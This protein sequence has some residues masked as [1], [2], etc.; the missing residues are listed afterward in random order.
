MIR[1]YN[2]LIR[3]KEEF[4]PIH[5]GKVGM[6]SCGPT[7]Y[8]FAHIGNMRSFLFADVLRRTLE[9][10]GFEVKQ[11]MNITDVGHL[12]GDT[13]DGQD[14]M[15]VAMKREGKSAYEIAEFY[16]TAFKKDLEALNIKPANIYPKA[17]DHI[18][19]QIEMV[20]AL[21]KNGFTYQ[22]SD[23]IYFDTSKLADYGRLS[24]QRGEEK[25]AGARVEM[26]EKRN[27][28]DFALWKFS[29]EGSDRDMEWDSP[30]GKGFPGWHIEC[31]AMSLKYLDA[32]FDIHTGGVDHIAVHHENEIAQTM[33]AE[34]VLE[35][36]VWMHNEFLTVDNGKMSKSLGNLFTVE[37]LVAKGYDPLVYRYFVLGGHYRSKL[38]FTF[39][40]LDAAQNALHKL[41]ETVRSWP[42]PG[43]IPPL[44]SRGTIGCADLENEFL[45]ALNDD[46]S[47]PQALSIVW[48]L[49]DAELPVDA[50]AKTL[51]WMDRVLGLKLEEYLGHALRVPPE[52]AK[53]VEQREEAR[54]QKDWP[55]SDELRDQ[56]QQSGYSV[57]DT[58]GGSKIK[59]N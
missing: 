48:K 33:G 6:Y 44:A 41:R 12:T 50:K 38:N 1:F 58:D 45:A 14:K 53:L 5:E 18:V 59:L 27:A 39:E 13:D 7:V 56:I 30:W 54:K 11:V 52:V 31:S 34:G 35:A 16:T 49:V 43:T 37:E 32:P 19:E 42:T 47:T 4:R 26:G 24:G 55:R 22:T 20:A 23:G 3:Q 51:L 40:G 8:W 29:A 25:K 21:E 57:E 28:T 36:N 46:L 15:I 17:T 10:N 9:L 2:T